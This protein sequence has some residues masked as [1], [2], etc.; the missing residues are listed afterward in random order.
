MVVRP[1][2]LLVVGRK[3]PAAAERADD[4]RHNTFRPQMERA[5]QVEADFL[6]YFILSYLSNVGL[7]FFLP[8]ENKSRCLS[9]SFA[10]FNEGLD[11]IWAWMQ[12]F[13]DF[14]LTAAIILMFGCTKAVLARIK[15]VICELCGLR[16]SDRLSRVR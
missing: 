14:V 13:R 9:R 3:R 2:L 6:L 1:H 15:C 16:R 8:Q 7:Y 10:S 4:G 12:Y 5:H 11:A